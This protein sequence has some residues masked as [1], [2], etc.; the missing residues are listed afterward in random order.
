MDKIEEIFNEALVAVKNHKIQVEARLSCSKYQLEFIDRINK[1][2]QTIPFDYSVVE[3]HNLDVVIS[4]LINTSNFW[5]KVYQPRNN[6]PS[7]EDYRI[8]FIRYFL[9]DFWHDVA[10]NCDPGMSK[11]LCEPG[12]TMYSFTI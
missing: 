5:N 8:S 4:D 10:M 9:I 7:N 1:K 2:V 3:G 6:N 11:A 12:N